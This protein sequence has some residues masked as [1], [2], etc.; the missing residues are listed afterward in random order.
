MK[1]LYTTGDL[2]KQTGITERSIRYYSNL[3]LLNTIKNNRGQ[4]VLVQSDLVN[5]VQILVSK[6]LGYRLKELKGSTFQMN[7]LGIEL[8]QKI[9]D[10]ENILIHLDNQENDET[11]LNTLYLLHRFN[12]KY[13]PQR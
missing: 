12:I 8:H 9:A 2:Y 3:D 13:L 4:L 1:V 10:L 7:D 11:L 6:I 5:L